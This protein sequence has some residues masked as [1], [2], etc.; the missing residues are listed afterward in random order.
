ML[1]RSGMG[2]GD[3]TPI[4]VLGF[5]LGVKN[6]FLNI[7]LSFV[8]GSIISIFLLVSKLKTRKDPIPFGP[9]I[10]LSFF[11]VLLYGEELLQFYW[12]IM[13]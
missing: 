2:G 5:V 10:I 7:F 11:L 12:G 8:L 1:F 6:I 9:F 3:V 4:G 13:S